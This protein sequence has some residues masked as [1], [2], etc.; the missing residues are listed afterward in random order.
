MENSVDG[1]NDKKN[2]ERNLGQ[3]CFLITSS[4]NTSRCQYN[5]SRNEKYLDFSI[6]C[7]NHDGADD[8]HSYFR[9]FESVSSDNQNKEKISSSD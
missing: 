1:R 2:S 8:H 5:T 6:A 3:Y 7:S 9:S 4:V